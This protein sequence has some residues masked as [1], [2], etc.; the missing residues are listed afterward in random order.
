MSVEYWYIEDSYYRAQETLRRAI[1]QYARWNR[2]IYIGLT[3]QIPEIRFAQHQKK[4]AKGHEWDK[5]IVIYHARTFSLMQTVEDRLIQYARNQFAKKN[6]S[7][8]ILND[9]NSQ[10]PMVC[11]NPNGYWIYILIQR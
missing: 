9:K 7:C 4:W 5:M 2:Y 10:R 11:K 3:Q 8:Q 6:Y 1:G